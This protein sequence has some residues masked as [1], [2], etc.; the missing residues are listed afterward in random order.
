MRDLASR[1]PGGLWAPHTVVSAVIDRSTRSRSQERAVR[2]LD[3]T[4]IVDVSGVVITNP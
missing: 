2:A 3:L 4:L 1:K